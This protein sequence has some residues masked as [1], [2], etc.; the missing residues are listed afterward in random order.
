MAETNRLTPSK[1]PALSPD[2]SAITRTVL[3]TG[4][5]SGIGHAAA[6]ALSRR[7]H[8]VIAVGRD[9]QRLEALR[10]QAPGIC[11]LVADLA[12]TSGLQRLAQSVLESYPLLDAVIHNAG[13]QHDVN[14]QDAE[15]GLAAVQAEIGTNL[16]APIEL[17]RLLLPGLMKR[18]SSVVMFV[19]SGLAL[20]PKS[21]ASVYCATKGGL[22]SFAA[23][24]RG[25][26]AGSPVRVVELLPPLVDT[27]MTQGR[28]RGKVSPAMVAAQIA[29]ALDGGPDEV[30]VG[31]TRW[32]QAL[33]RLAPGTARR[34]M[35]RPVAVPST[36][37]PP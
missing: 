34:L 24:L 12:A 6:L 15:Y 1:E 20:A 25:Q 36:A 16:L 9:A 18:E 23:S 13:I 19:T 35:L 10:A 32:L 30:L 17:T 4:A 33:L 26:L 3:L 5:S 2:P 7:G 21:T 29:A 22:H 28:G 8:R 27:P 31:K 11:V 37:T 14:L